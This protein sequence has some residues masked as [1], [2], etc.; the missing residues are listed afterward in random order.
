MPAIWSV[1]LRK[2]VAFYTIPGYIIDAG[3]CLPAEAGD[4]HARD[5]ATAK[6]DVRANQQAATTPAHELI[7]RLREVLG[8]PLTMYLTDVRDVRT[9]DRWAAKADVPPLQVR[10][11]QAAYAAALVLQRRYADP[12]HI[13]T[14]FTWLAET[15]DDV[16]PAAYLRAAADLEDAENRARAVLRAARLYLAD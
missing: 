11:L 13:A 9:L 12:V 14:W 3:L 15:L 8:A 1:I 16:S 6:P 2:N 10:R 4:M 5:A 7:S